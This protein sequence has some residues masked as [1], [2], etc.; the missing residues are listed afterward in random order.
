MTPK[1]YKMLE[2]CFFMASNTDSFWK[3]I[4][5]VF[6]AVS[7]LLLGTLLMLLFQAE[8]REMVAGANAFED[9]EQALSF[10]L[11]DNE[12]LVMG[13]PDAKLVIEEYSDFQCPYCKKFFESDA[14][15]QIK[16]KYVETGKVL[17]VF[18]DFP[19]TNIHPYALIAAQG[20]SCAN[21]EGKGFDM[22]DK[23]FSS[24]LSPTEENLKK[25][26]AEL[27]LNE[28]AFAECLDSGKYE[29]EAFDDQEEGSAKGITGTPSFLIGSQKVVGA[30]PFANFEKVIEEEL[31]KVQ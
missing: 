12:D 15:Q 20:A 14:Y 25:W 31:A 11:S 10:A 17:L 29:Q 24:S 9:G 27:G 13:N 19:L 6:G 26:A 16:E 3:S 21:E 18:K 5:L 1:F 30:Q 23:I 28:A 7:V 2:S 8:G 4:S 22:H